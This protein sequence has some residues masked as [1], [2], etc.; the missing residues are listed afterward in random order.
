MDG[1]LVMMGSIQ[2]KTSGGVEEDNVIRDCG[3]RRGGEG[4]LLQ[5]LL[6]LQH[7]Q[8]GRLRTLIP[9]MFSAKISPAASSRLFWGWT[10]ECADTNKA[11]TR[12]GSEQDR[13]IL[14][15]LNNADI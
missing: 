7:H 4:G 5:E 11:P 8:R 6:V 15:L 13:V 3:P 1:R 12:C 9:C 14:I 2:W 10:F